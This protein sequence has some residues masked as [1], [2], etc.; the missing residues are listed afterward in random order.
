MKRY[1][2]LLVLVSAFARPMWADPQ[3]P[4]HLRDAEQLLAHMDLSNTSYNTNYGHEHEMGVV[5]WD[6]L[7]LACHTDCSGLVSNLLMHSYGYTQEAF[8]RWFGD[9]WPRAKYYFGAI[10]SG[11]GFLSLQHVWDLQPGDFIAIK[12]IGLAKSTGHIMIVEKKPWRVKGGPPFVDGTVQWLVTVIDCS[13]VGHGKWD[14]RYKR[15]ANGKDHDGLGQGVFR[16]YCDK[17]GQVV[18]YCWS[19]GNLSVFKGPDAAPVALGR[20]IPDFKP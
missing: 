12:Y 10:K 11:N 13:G 17:L 18:G 7:E 3:K 14:T 16:L 15:G 6:P 5:V 2:F 1:L 20:L 9:K 4:V 19:P 8:Q